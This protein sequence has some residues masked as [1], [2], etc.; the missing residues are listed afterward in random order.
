MTA[1]QG[2]TARR[3]V[4]IAAGLTILGIAGCAAPYRDGDGDWSTETPPPVEMPPAE[5]PPLP[6]PVESAPP[7]E[8]GGEVEE[9]GPIPRFPSPPPEPTLRYAL[10]RGLLVHSSDD[11][12]GAV[13]DRIV[14]ALRRGEFD[15]WSVYAVLDDGFAVVCRLEHI[16]EDGSRGDPPFS[17]E[18]PPSRGFFLWRYLRDLFTSDPGRYRVIVLMVRNTIEPGYG[19]APAESTMTALLRE[20]S[21]ALP[22]WLRRKPAGGAQLHALIYEF[23]RPNS[24]VEPVMVTSAHS[25]ISAVR[26]LTGARLWREEDL[27]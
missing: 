10:Q 11:T 5:P 4:G 13:F 25:A 12:L 15:T 17:K 24:Q 20:G 19:A 14:V 7:S 6:T 1:F 26:H 18:P 8:S 27:Q 23:H 2:I 22:E 3:W 9:G 16:N 21:D